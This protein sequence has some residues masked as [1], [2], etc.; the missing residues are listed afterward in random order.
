MREVAEIGRKAKM[1]IDLEVKMIP[2]TE[3]ERKEELE[4]MSRGITSAQEVS[5]E[6]RDRN[7]KLFEIAEDVAI[8]NGKAEMSDEQSLALRYMTLFWVEEESAKRTK[9]YGKGEWNS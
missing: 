6:I 7:D 5:D 9:A 3:G 8:K 1:K 4:K 2:G